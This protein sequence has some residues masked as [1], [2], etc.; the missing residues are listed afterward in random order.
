MSEDRAPY[1][2]SGAELT[3]WQLLDLLQWSIERQFDVWEMERIRAL[4][5]RRRRGSDPCA[6]WAL[7]TCADARV[8]LSSIDRSTRKR[9]GRLG[10]ASRSVRCT[11]TW[12]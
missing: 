2:M 4:R 1:A 5:K 11:G 9:C 3:L 6:S 12:Q 10:R 7:A 8:R